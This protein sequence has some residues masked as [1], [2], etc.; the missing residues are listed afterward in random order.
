MLLKGWRLLGLPAHPV[1][2]TAPKMRVVRLFRILNLN[3]LFGRNI[4]SSLPICRRDNFWECSMR[5]CPI[6]VKESHE[7]DVNPMSQVI[8]TPVGKRCDTTPRNANPHPYIWPNDQVFVVALF[9]L[10]PVMLI[11]GSRNCHAIQ[12]ASA[13]ILE[14]VPLPC[15]SPDGLCRNAPAGTTSVYARMSGPTSDRLE[16]QGISPWSVIWPRCRGIRAQLPP[17]AHGP[18]GLLGSNG[19]QQV[20]VKRVKGLPQRPAPQKSYSSP[21]F[22]VNVNRVDG[23]RLMERPFRSAGRAT[24][25]R[26]QTAAEATRTATAR[27][28]FG[29]FGE[30]RL[31]RVEAKPGI[32][33]PATFTGVLAA[34]NNVEDRSSVPPTLF[35]GDS[36]EQALLRS[37]STTIARVGRPR[38]FRDAVRRFRAAHG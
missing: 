38:R 21:T 14:L 2:A 16:G 24:R 32:L 26:D 12:S 23:D 5:N 17:C 30:R 29:D 36:G 15:H 34:G 13:Q 9:A 4:R 1:M 10:M 37:V 8:L 33:F 19:A 27:M 22:S 28:G 25:D 3:G 18:V 31:R 7:I 20:V 35:G 11:A 6:P